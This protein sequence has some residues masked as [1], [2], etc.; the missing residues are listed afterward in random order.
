M[1]EFIKNWFLI[2]IS[3]II[4]MTYAKSYV[5]RIGQIES[6]LWDLELNTSD[7]EW[8]ANRPIN[9]INRIGDLYYS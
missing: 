1:I 2:F 9:G 8:F 7:L 3:F 6:E 5:D 4:G